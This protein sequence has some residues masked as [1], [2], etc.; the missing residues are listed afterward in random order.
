MPP[1][2]HEDLDPQHQ[3]HDDA[4]GS[5]SALNGRP[6][7]HDLVYRTQGASPPKPGFQDFVHR[8]NGNPEEAGDHRSDYFHNVVAAADARGHLTPQSKSYGAAPDSR[9][10]A[11]NSSFGNPLASTAPSPPPLTTQDVL[12]LADKSE[13]GAA[14]RQFKAR[15]AEQQRLSKELADAKQVLQANQDNIRSLQNLRETLKWTKKGYDYGRKRLPKHL[16]DKVDKIM[17]ET[18]ADPAA[19]I[20]SLDAMIKESEARTAGNEKAIQQAE[21]AY[22]QAFKAT[23][24]AAQR[25]RDLEEQKKRS[26]VSPP[27]PA[28]VP[29]PSPP[30]RSNTNCQHSLGRD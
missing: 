4:T 18:G 8:Y 27:A 29:T 25:M 12:D 5:H 16:R 22:R 14:K 17:E 13:L 20:Q 1:I 3:E 26:P 19:Q 24:D 2:T 9:G 10:N 7:V 15:L 23:Q 28:P 30:P 21:E 11:G 6:E